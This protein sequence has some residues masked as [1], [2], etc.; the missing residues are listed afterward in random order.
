MATPLSATKIKE[1]LG[2]F[3]VS[4]RARVGWA[5][6]NRGQRG[7][8]WGIT[9]ENKTGVHG[10]MIHHTGPFQ[11]EAGML[12]LLWAGYEGLPGPLCH[13]GIP[14]DGTVHLMSAGRANH[15][16]TGDPLVLARVI[17]ENYATTL[18]KPRFADG[19]AGGIDGNAR[20][21]GLE[22][23]NQGDGKDAWSVAQ[24]RGMVRA[25]AAFCYGHGWTE[26]SVIGHKEWQRGK[27]DPRG[28]DMV[29]FRMA[30]RAELVQMRAKRR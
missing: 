20:F 27:P 10:V 14:D 1:L 9:E 21:Y 6:H 13:G 15:A 22:A 23:L 8:G 19:E 25:A 7:D 28:V 4:Y 2:L 29:A 24:M 30:V 5:S 3:G 11:T 18:P 17:A 26:R 12:N 16:G